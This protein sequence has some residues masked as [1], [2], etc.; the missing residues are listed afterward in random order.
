VQDVSVYDRI[1]AVGAQ[2]L[3]GYRPMV[4]HRDLYTVH[5]GLV[6][7]LAEGLGI[8]AFTNELWTD[9]RIM[10]DGKEPSEEERRI[11]SERLLLGQARVALRELPHPEHGTVLVG[12]G[13][14]FSARIPPP[15]ML[16][17]ELHRNFAF[18]MYH[19]DQMPLLRV[20]SVDTAELSPGTWSVTAC[21]ANDRL[22]PTRTARSADKGIG[23]D[24]VATLTGA[25]VAA[26]GAAD[27]R[28]ART[29]A[30]TGFRPEAIH[31]PRGVPGL[32]R[33]CVRFL[34]RGQR[35]TPVTVRWSAEK[36]KDVEAT[37]K[38]GESIPQAAAR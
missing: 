17:E 26:G 35:G 22:I 15:F 13:T 4:I 19:A 20:E 31:F 11:W 18:T 36:A 3:P 8:I 14:K 6:N 38:L 16:E 29:F 7:W 2:M 34:V 1:Q 12:G 37:V 27:R 30:P 21:I 23:L 10:Q 9:K 25:T 32:G 33:E 5:G 28:D 24:D